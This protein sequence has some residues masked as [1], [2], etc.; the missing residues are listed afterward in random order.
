MKTKLFIVL[1]LIGLVACSPNDPNKNGSNTQRDSK[2]NIIY[3]GESSY[4]D[5]YFSGK[6]SFISSIS[7]KYPEDT[8]G[9]QYDRVLRAE[10]N[11]ITLKDNSQLQIHDD[12]QLKNDG[13]STELQLTRSWRLTNEEQNSPLQIRSKAM[14]SGDY[15]TSS[16]TYS[17]QSATPISIIRP[18][19]DNCDPL[20]LCYYDNFI[21]EWNG[22]ANNQNGIV[23]I[24]EWNGVTISQPPH[25][26]SV[27][28]VDIIEDNGLAVLNTDLF[29]DMPDEALVNLWLIRGNL[30][31]IDEGNLTLKDLLNFYPQEIEELL[32]DNPE[33]ILQL[34]PFM[35]GSGAISSLSFFLVKKL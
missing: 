16:F 2:L 11:A 19:I 4:I 17:I 29:K 1:S 13:K 9:H 30:I 7:R 26:I 10:D 22:D 18:V 12:Y 5:W 21:I 15:H 8:I 31:D 20:P 34:Q 6:E 3:K 25:D 28:N 27:A 14:S 33:L 24:T 32:T 35:F 23:V